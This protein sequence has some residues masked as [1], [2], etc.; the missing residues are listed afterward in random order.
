[1]GAGGNQNLMLSG[2]SFMGGVNDIGGA[3]AQSQAIKS[4]GAFDR[5]QLEFD[6]KMAELQADD[7]I[8]RSQILASKARKSGKQLVGSQKTA[9]AAG[10]VSVDTGSATDVFSETRALSELDAITIKSNAMQEAWGYKMQASNIFSQ[11]KYIESST[12]YSA[13]NTLLSG[14]MKALNSSMKGGAYLSSYLKPEGR[15][16]EADYS[17]AET[18][19]TA[20]MRIGSRK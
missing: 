14:G 8:K 10:N 1:M 20:G 7:V 9:Y 16:P 19:I 11:S 13:T 5:Q 6:Q 4:K 2:L 18:S 3:Y 17:G 12:S 15:A